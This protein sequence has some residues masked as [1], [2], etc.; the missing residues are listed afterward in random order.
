VNFAL[1]PNDG[2]VTSE[3]GL[4][5]VKVYNSDGGFVG[6][7][8]GHNDLTDGV[9]AKICETPEQ[10]QG[11]GLDVAADAEGRVYILDPE[12]NV[13]RIFVGKETDK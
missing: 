8:A 4:V 5:R 3:K 7:V 6:V 1:L 11:A 2:F 13:I 10:C 12:K 9:L